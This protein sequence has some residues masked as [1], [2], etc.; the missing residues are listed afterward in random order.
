MRHAPLDPPPLLMMSAPGSGNAPEAPPRDDAERVPFSQLLRRGV[1]RTAARFNPLPYVQP[2]GDKVGQ[3]PGEVTFVGDA[4]AGPPRLSVVDYDAEHLAAYEPDEARAI[5][6]LRDQPTTTW[7]NLDGLHDTALI[8]EIGE[9]FGLHPLVLEDIAHTGQRP[10]VEVF[11]DEGGGYFFIVVKMLTYDDE[12]QV[13]ASEQV[14]LAAGPGWLISFQE[15]PG[16]VFD[17]VR[18][19][20]QTGRGRIRTS[21]SDYLAYAL[22]DVIVDHYFLVLEA[23]GT[24]TEEIEEEI[25][26]GDPDPAV[27][28]RLNRLRRDLILMRR[29]VWPMRDL[30]AT[31]ERGGTG[32][33]EG[34]VGEP[35]RPFLRDTYD[36]A[37]Q[38]MDIL[39]SLRDVTSGLGDLYMSALSHRMNEVMQVLTIIGTIFIPLTFIAGVYGMNFEYIPELTWRYSYFVAMGA[40][41]LIG[42]ALLIYFRRKG[43]L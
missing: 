37:V 41:G 3:R 30:F 36:H 16:D 10:K 39:E 7:I 38:V 17:P 9:H 26:E 25:T 2:H 27:Q 20:L 4:P 40:M 8:K 21:G 28:Q 13:L 43:W 14:S 23:F 1:A 18:R 6:P 29:A 5:H 12:Q 19:R 33:E 24:R 11:P 34:I 31:L 22:L 42:A 15:H 35:V 32:G